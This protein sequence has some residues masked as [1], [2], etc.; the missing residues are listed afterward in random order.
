MIPL[1]SC[2]SLVSVNQLS[3]TEPLK[4]KHT[5]H[6]PCRQIVGF[7]HK[8]IA[9]HGPFYKQPWEGKVVGGLCICVIIG[10]SG[11]AKRKPFFLAMFHSWKSSAIIFNDP[12]RT[13]LAMKGRAHCSM[14]ISQ[15]SQFKFEIL[16]LRNGEK[17]K[18]LMNQG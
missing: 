12:R 8:V 14:C 1:L 3:A 7:S 6:T 9:I 16:R 17:H 2:C 4:H 5:P 13:T 11:F 18:A 15:W 10:E